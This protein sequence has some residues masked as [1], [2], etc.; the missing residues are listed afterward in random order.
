MAAGVG[1][2]TSIQ[3]SNCNW[4]A[5]DGK[6]AMPIKG[7]SMVQLLPEEGGAG[8]EVSLISAEGEE[9]HR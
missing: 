1:E 5:K 8:A 7:H 6:G 3:G 4:R 9:R 2:H